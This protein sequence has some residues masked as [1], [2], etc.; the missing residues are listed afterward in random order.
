MVQYIYNSSPSVQVCFSSLTKPEGNIAVTRSPSEERSL[1]TT[2]TTTK[3]SPSGIRTSPPEPNKGLDTPPYVPRIWWEATLLSMTMTIE[4]GIEYTTE[5]DLLHGDVDE[6][7]CGIPDGSKEEDSDA[8]SIVPDENCSS[9]SNSGVGDTKTI[10]LHTTR[11]QPE[12]VSE[13][14]CS[15]RRGGVDMEVGLRATSFEPLLG[16]SEPIATIPDVV[17]SRERAER[18][19]STSCIS[20]I[21]RRRQLATKDEAKV[22]I[23]LFQQMSLTRLFDKKHDHLAYL[24]IFFTGTH[25]VDIHYIRIHPEV[26]KESRNGLEEWCPWG[27]SPSPSLICDCTT[28]LVLECGLS[29]AS[30]TRFPKLPRRIHIPI[31]LPHRPSPSPDDLDSH[32]ADPMLEQPDLFP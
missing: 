21:A 23:P 2:S 16:K 17:C 5:P 30:R 11:D 6:K 9:N 24:E 15:R 26:A 18:S 1:V 19:T 7:Y 31:C 3:T 14:D 25:M 28:D 8:S 4:F 10:P 27:M 13:K 20:A 29:W 12:P 32:V 22:P